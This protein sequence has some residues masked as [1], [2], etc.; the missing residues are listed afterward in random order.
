ME[1]VNVCVIKDPITGVGINFS[2]PVGVNK[3]DI[4]KDLK[5]L[6][7]ELVAFKKLPFIG[8]LYN[9][10]ESEIV[11]DVYERI[12]VQLRDFE[13]D[14]DGLS[15]RRISNSFGVQILA[16][17]LIAFELNF[18]KDKQE[19]LNIADNLEKM[20]KQ[21]EELKNGKWSKNAKK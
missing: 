1:T 11:E 5:H 18:G 10:T 19:L 2:L 20:Q 4:P 14:V 13:E 12:R 8:M 3:I 15:C 6:S 17:R 16:L 21:I 9:F 7:W